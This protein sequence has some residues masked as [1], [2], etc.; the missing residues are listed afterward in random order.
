MRSNCYWFVTPGKRSPRSWILVPL[1]LCQLCGVKY[2]RETSCLSFSTYKIKPLNKTISKE[3]P[4][5]LRGCLPTPVCPTDCFQR[6]FSET[7]I[8]LFSCKIPSVTHFYP[9]N[10]NLLSLALRTYYKLVLKSS[11]WLSHALHKPTLQLNS[12]TP[13]LSRLCQASTSAFAAPKA[14]CLVL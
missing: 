8:F 14:F 5:I 12:A 3:M 4:Q 6:N 1:C 10:L 2:A 9:I 13:F 7:P 11:T